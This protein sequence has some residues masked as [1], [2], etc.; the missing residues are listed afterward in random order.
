MRI[1]I[2]PTISKLQ[3]VKPVNGFCGAVYRVD[4]PIVLVDEVE[5]HYVTTSIGLE[6]ILGENV[7][8]VFASDEKGQF[9]DWEAIY[10]D[11][12]GPSWCIEKLL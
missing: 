6:T 7:F 5:T 12:E 10:A 9:L 2:N 8:A 4:P 1:P 11:G 3:G